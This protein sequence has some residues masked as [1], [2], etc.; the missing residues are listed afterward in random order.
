MCAAP[1]C[2]A[3]TYGVALAADGL[4]HSQPG[5]WADISPFDFYAGGDEFRV[6][7]PGGNW[8]GEDVNTGWRSDLL[9]VVGNKVPNVV[10]DPIDDE[11]ISTV[12]VSGVSNLSTQGH[13]VQLRKLTS[14]SY[15]TAVTVAW[16]AHGQSG[17]WTVATVE[18]PAVMYGYG[19]DTT[20]GFGGVAIEVNRL[21]DDDDPGSLRYAL[22]YAHAR[23][24]TPTLSGTVDLDR[25]IDVKSDLTYDGLSGAGH[26]LVVKR[27]M[28]KIVDEHNIII[29]NLAMR[30]GDEENDDDNDENDAGQD[31]NTAD[32][33]DALSC[34][35][36]RQSLPASPATGT[37]VANPGSK[38]VSSITRA[39]NVATVTTGSAHGWSTGQDVTISGANQTEYNVPARITVTGASTFTYPVVGDPRDVYN[40]YLDHCDM[41]WGPDIGGP[42]FLSN[43]HDITIVDCVIGEG[44]KLSRHPEGVTFNADGSAAN[45]HAMGMNIAQQDSDWVAHGLG[46]RDNDGVQDDLEIVTPRR[47]TLYRNLITTNRDR[48]PRMVRPEYI[49]VVNNVLYNNWNAP[50]GTVRKVNLVN[51]LYRKGPQS[52]R[53]EIY[54]PTTGHELGPTSAAGVY[55][56][57]NVGEDSDASDGLWGLIQG[58]ANSLYSS[59]VHEETTGSFS[60]PSADLMTAESAED[61]VLG[62][63]GATVGGVRDAVTARIIDNVSDRDGDFFSGP[64]TDTT[65]NPP[66][67]HPEP[68]PYW[69]DP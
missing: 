50:S 33:R 15:G 32:E 14:E 55:Q 67:T 6:R 45:G 13:K 37:I 44:L 64:G 18:A 9:S 42:S 5:R 43:C 22:E 66:L 10:I 1:V 17:T 68:H 30:P 7:L 52:K 21:D 61:Y 29:R 53:N 4:L 48:V 35:G 63:A 25:D 11:P 2:D 28:L 20:G 51:N 59:T 60:I 8:V 41:I 16:T 49:D 54:R 57:G 23:I 65:V 38:A 34:N 31:R 40:I 3:N 24:V 26:L 36:T 62:H 12:A 39:A 56:S 58:G 69:P 27:G 47:I 19:A 46:D